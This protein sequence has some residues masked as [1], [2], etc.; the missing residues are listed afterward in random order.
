MESK[1]LNNKNAFQKR[2]EELGI[3]KTQI[4]TDLKA[5]RKNQQM[6]KSFG[7]GVRN[8]ATMSDQEHEESKELEAKAK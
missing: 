3:G 6:A 2:L 4:K 5:V 1:G 8:S 7:G